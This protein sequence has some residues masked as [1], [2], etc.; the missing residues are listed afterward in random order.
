MSG[1]SMDGLD[2][3]YCTFEEI[4]GKWSFQINQADCIPFDENWKSML[5]QITQF[6]GKELMLAHTAFGKWMG[7][8][9]QQFVE[10]HQLEHKVHLIASHGHTVFHEPKLG[11]TF[12]LG[13]GAAIAAITQLPVVSDLRNMDVALGGQGAPII[14]IG[15]KYLWSEYDCFLN[16]GGISNITIKKGNEHIAYDVCP[17]NRVLNLLASELNLTYDDRG[18]EAQKG[19]LNQSL[20]N[21]LNELDYYKHSYPKSLSNE[22]GI[23]IVYPIIQNYPISIQD[24]LN[25]MCEHIAIQIANEVDAHQVKNC[26]MLVTGGGALNT[27]LITLI[28]EKL[29]A[30]DVEVIVPDMNLIQYKEA[31]VMALIGILRWREEVNVLESVTGAKRSSVGG[32]LWMGQD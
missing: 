25:T 26:K 3:A 20:L 24:K 13:D 14:P 11:M 5:H 17:A 4:G 30:N 2:I 29:V 21:Q 8:A 22:F 12:Q 19:Q 32:A 1:S 9:I 28:K 18:R 31:V 10:T 7:E 16:I 23:D 27:F 6:N 15:E